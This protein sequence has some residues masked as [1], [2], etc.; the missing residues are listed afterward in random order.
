MKKKKKRLPVFKSADD[1]ARFWET[2]SA[3][4]YLSDLEPVD[5]IFLSPSLVKKIK[6]RAKKRLISLRL[7]TWEIEKSKQIAKKKHIPYQA[8][9]RQWIDQ[10]LRAEYN[11]Q[12]K[13]A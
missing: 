1:E 8:L 5:D 2:H 9:M 11:N 7:A 6:D 4:D 3:V 12:N 10:G 13:A